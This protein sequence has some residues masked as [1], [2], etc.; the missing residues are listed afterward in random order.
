MKY[1][2]EKKKIRNE[3]DRNARA[4]KMRRGVKHFDYVI[5]QVILSLSLSL[6]LYFLHSI[7]HTSFRYFGLSPFHDSSPL[8]TTSLL[9]SLLFYDEFKDT[10]L[11][12]PRFFSAIS[13]NFSN[14]SICPP[15]VSNTTIQSL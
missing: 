9:F 15:E 10:E 2:K 3:I 11:H 4:E 7:S 5:N 6:S 1:V 8:F 12:L 14:T 13:A